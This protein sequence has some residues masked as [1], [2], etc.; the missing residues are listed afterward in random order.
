MLQLPVS[1]GSEHDG[2]PHHLDEN[3]GLAV[4]FWYLWSASTPLPPCLA[5]GGG[6]SRLAPRATNVAPRVNRVKSGGI[7]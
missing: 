4:G 1:L 5:P 2:S 3:L 7:D 6:G